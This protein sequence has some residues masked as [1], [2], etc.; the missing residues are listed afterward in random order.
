MIGVPTTREDGL[1]I[2]QTELGYAATLPLP[3]GGRVSVSELPSEAEAAEAIRSAV[4][5][6]LTERAVSLPRTR[7]ERTVPELLRRARA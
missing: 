6:I 1:T 7:A 2:S 4:E 5:G 3:N